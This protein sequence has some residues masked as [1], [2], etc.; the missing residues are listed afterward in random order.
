MNP[1]LDYYMEFDEKPVG[2]QTNRSALE[3]YT[4]GGKGINVSIVLNNLGVPS[5]AFGF[6]G[7]FSKDFYISLLAQYEEIRPYFTYTEGHTRVNVKLRAPGYTDTDMNAA[8]PHITDADMKNLMLKTET[9]YAG[10]YFVL[11][12]NTQSYLVDSTV[13]MLRGIIK[14][15]GR[16]V[17]DT[18]TAIMKT[19]LKDKP[20]MYKITPHQAGEILDRSVNTEE[21]AAEAAR[22]IHKKGA[23]MTIILMDDSGR[24]IMACDEGTFECRILNQ[25]KAVNTVGTGDSM[26][27]GFLMDYM[28]SKD[29]IDSFRFGA[30]CGSATAYSKTLATREKIDSMYESTEIVKLKD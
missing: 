11:A 23:S 16:V 1:S 12:G 6:L 10:D 27:A 21:E 2:G 13:K 5:R 14:E 17:L 28:R 8:G 24:A 19:I 26:V 20:F 29:S 15:K 7:G 4:A 9:I 18:N 25:G 3:Y 22:E 30:S